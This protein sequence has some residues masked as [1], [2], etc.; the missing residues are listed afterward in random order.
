MTLLV[1]HPDRLNGNAA[2]LVVGP[3]RQSHITIDT[4]TSAQRISKYPVLFVVCRGPEADDG[5][6][7]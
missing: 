7:E 6:R 4:P 2:V 3:N 1:I 5:Q